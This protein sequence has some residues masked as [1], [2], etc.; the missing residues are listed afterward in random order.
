MPDNTGELVPA[1][2]TAYTQGRLSEGNADTI[3]LLDVALRMARRY[4]GWHVTPVKTA[5]PFT[6]DGPAAK[7][8]VLP[9]LRLTAITELAEDGTTLDVAADIAFSQRGLVRKSNGCFWS[10]KFGAIVGKMTH[11]FVEA[12]DWQAAVL[13]VA[14]R[15]SDEPSGGQPN[16]VGPFQWPDRKALA[17]VFTTTERF[18][19]DIY[20]LEAAP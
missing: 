14:D 17:D 4:C 7:L 18:L 20:S 9:T 15:L 11:G 12:T 1:D 13:S 8:L 16:V 5:D 10:G 2:L 6:F 19:L 3:R